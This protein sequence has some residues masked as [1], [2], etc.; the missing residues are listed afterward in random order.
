MV[1]SFNLYAVVVTYNPIIN[2]LKG[3]LDDILLCGLKV[4]VVD[5][6]SN[7]Q[8]DI[9]DLIDN[10]D[11]FLYPVNENVGIAAAQ[12][13]GMKFCI[14]AGAEYFIFFDQDS[15]VD[16]FFVK[17]LC[18]DYNYLIKK[19][20]N[21]GII[22]PKYID[23]RFNFTYSAN[24]VSK[25]GILKKI[26]LENIVNPIPVKILISSG[27]LISVE[28]VRKIG[29]LKE[30]YFID[31]VDTEWCFRAE[32]FGYKNY[33]SSG[34][35]ME[36]TIGDNLI[37]FGP[38]KTPLHS[39]FRRYHI[40]R[41]SFYMLKEPYI[42]FLF[43]IRMIFFAFYQQILIIFYVSNKKEY[44]TSLFKGIVDGIKYLLIGNAK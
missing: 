6:G 11:I 26:K 16:S 22:G 8:E 27:S 34:A 44:I 36:H 13:I 38:L 18:Q 37:K 42:P 43:S 31:C 28:T 23:P 10:K 1:N 41:N 25:F 3:L 5:N 24:D 4:I 19:N 9:N 33:I 21:V 7:N 39:P 30:N 12:N 29:F 35:A 17:N 40:V 20:I 14:K 15:R 2:S 32:S